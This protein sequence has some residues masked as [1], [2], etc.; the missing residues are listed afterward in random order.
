MTTTNSDDKIGYFHVKLRHKIAENL[1]IHQQLPI[2]DITKIY[3]MF[4]NEN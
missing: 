1:F 2:E 4:S 3:D